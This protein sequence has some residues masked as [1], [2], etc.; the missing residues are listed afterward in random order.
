MNE[1]PNLKNGAEEEQTGMWPKFRDQIPAVLV[2]TLLVTG[3]FAWMRSN[4]FKEQEAAL[5]PL[6]EQ[7]EALRAQADVN[8]KQI[9]AATQLLREA[10]ARHEGELFKTDVEIRKLNTER[11]NAL[12]SAIADKV[13]PILPG[14]KTPEE[15]ARIEND[16]IEKISS[17]TA[18]KLQTALTEAV[19]KQP[20]VTD[21]TIKG[22]NGRIQQLNASLQATQAAA[23]DA[24]KLSHEIAAM[25]LDTYSD[26]G[27][28]V[29]VLALPTDII[30][31]VA[32]GDVID[33]RDRKKTERD[34]DE[35]MRAIERRLDEI[36]NQGGALT[37][38]N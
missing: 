28:L 32:A 19:N 12:A 13:E 18:E 9:E 1:N 14:P 21:A 16:Q 35:K 29:R 25:Y 2:T 33:A 37:A 6:R 8:R 17:R 5:A 34:L 24:L 31:D 23:Q 26:K 11:M 7:N 3:A 20:A 10:I 15:L 38:P 30:R 22:Y 27:M 4:S 36:R